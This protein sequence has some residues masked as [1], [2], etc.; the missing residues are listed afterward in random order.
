[1]HTYTYLPHGQVTSV[2]LNRLDSFLVLASDGLWDNFKCVLRFGDFGSDL[3]AL[4][5]YQSSVY[6]DGLIYRHTTCR[7]AHA[8]TRRNHA[9]PNLLTSSPKRLLRPVTWYSSR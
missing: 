8:H 4:H 3:S 1:M 5:L 7:R 6:S 2:T 9:P